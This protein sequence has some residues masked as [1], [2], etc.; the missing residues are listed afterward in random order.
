M[1]RLH[2]QRDYQA[3]RAQHETECKAAAAAAPLIAE[4]HSAGDTEQKPNDE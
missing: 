4:D 2:H 3:N 1:I